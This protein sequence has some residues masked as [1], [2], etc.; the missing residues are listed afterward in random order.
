VARGSF[1]KRRIAVTVTVVFT[2][3]FFRAIFSTW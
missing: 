1:L 2:T 3:V